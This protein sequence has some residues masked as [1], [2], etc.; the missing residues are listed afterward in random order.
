MLLGGHGT[1]GSTSEI[2]YRVRI[3][4]TELVSS[5]KLDAIVDRTKKGGGELVQLMGTSAWYAP[6]LLQLKWSLPSSRTKSVFFPVALKWKA[7][8]V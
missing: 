8:M 4:V 5:A 3:P 7:N 6:V 2:Y 1:H